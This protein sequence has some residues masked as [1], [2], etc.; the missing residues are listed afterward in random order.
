MKRRYTLSHILVVPGRTGVY[1]IGAAKAK[2][3]RSIRHTHNE[4]VFMYPTSDRTPIYWLSNLS[5]CTFPLGNSHV[6]IVLTFYSK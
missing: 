5:F 2:V 1:S 6:S 4:N 3:F